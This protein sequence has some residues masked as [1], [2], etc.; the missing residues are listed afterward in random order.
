MPGPDSAGAVTWLTVDRLAVHFDDNVAGPHAS[1]GGP[2]PRSTSATDGRRRAR[3]AVRAAVRSQGVIA[4]SCM[5]NRRGRRAG[6]SAPP[7][8]RRPPPL[9]VEVELLD[10]TLR[11]LR[12][13]S[14]YTVMGTV[15]SGFVAITARPASRVDHGSAVELHDDVPALESGFGGR[16]ASRTLTR[17]APFVLAARTRPLLLRDE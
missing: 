9:G 3:A 16:G 13:L 14:R 12:C 1:V 7:R 4:S 8:A 5:P 2:L 10:V 11:V 17:M 6:S 15:R